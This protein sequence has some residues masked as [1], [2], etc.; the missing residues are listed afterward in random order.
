MFTKP[1][2]WRQWPNWS[3]QTSKSDQTLHQ[4]YVRNQRWSATNHQSIAKIIKLSS[5][6]SWVGAFV[7]LQ[8]PTCRVDHQPKQ[9]LLHNSR[10]TLVKTNMWLSYSHQSKQNFPNYL[11]CFL[12]DKVFPQLLVHHPEFDMSTYGGWVIWWFR[13][14]EVWSGKVTQWPAFIWPLSISA[15]HSF[16]RC[17][18]LPCIP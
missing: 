9:T 18:S 3:I 17:L 5:P 14:W 7:D 12:H 8:I 2:W 4:T 13:V 10:S 1:K 11:F 6:S 16:G 15:L